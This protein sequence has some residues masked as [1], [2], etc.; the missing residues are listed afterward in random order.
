MTTHT[1]QVHRAIALCSLVRDPVDPKLRLD[2][3]KAA[4]RSVKNQDARRLIAKI[5]EPIV[6]TP[7]PETKP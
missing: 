4:L 3:F 6:F 2:R 5:T 7:E 1:A